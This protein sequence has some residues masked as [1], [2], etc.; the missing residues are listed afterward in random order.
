MISLHSPYASCIPDLP[1]AR[2]Y[3]VLPARLLAGCYPCDKDPYMASEKVRGLVDCGV[4]WVLSLME[5]TEVDHGRKDDIATLF[6]AFT[7]TIPALPQ[8]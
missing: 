8:S 7:Q 2:S 1:F 4:T 5:G 6:D 3:W